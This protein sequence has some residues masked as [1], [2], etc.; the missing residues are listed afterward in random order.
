MLTHR[1]DLT[2]RYRGD[3]VTLPS[4]KAV[5]NDRATKTKKSM[6]AAMSPKHV[7]V[8]KSGAKIFFASMQHSKDKTNYQGKRYDFIGFDELTHFTWEEYS[9][10]F[11]RNR[12]SKR[13]KSTKKTICYIRATTN[14]G[15][16]GHGWVKER[17]IDAAE[18]G[19]TIVEMVEV[20]MPDGTVR[21]IKRDRVFIQ[22]TI[23]DNQALLEND[24]GYLGSLALLPEKERDALLYGVWDVFE[25][26]YFTEFRVRPDPVKCKEAGITPEQALERHQWTHVIPAFD[27]N[28]GNRSGWKIYRSYDFGYAKPFSCAWWAVDYDGVMYRIMEMYGCTK[29]PNEG[30]KW[31]PDQ[32]F[33]QIAEIERTHPWLR[34]KNIMGVADPAIW[35]SSRG[36]SIQE[37]AAKYGVYFTPGDHE[38]I[39]GWMQCHYR[40]QFDHNG[41]SRMYV[42][43]NCKAFIRTIPLMMARHEAAHRDIA[44]GN[45]PRASEIYDRLV[46][47]Y[48]KS[49]EVELPDGSVRDTSEFIDWVIEQYAEA[50]SMTDYTADEVFEEIVCDSMADMNAFGEDMKPIVEHFLKDIKAQA[51]QMGGSQ[52]VETTVPGE[53]KFSREKAKAE[54]KRY[55]YEWFI[56]KPDMVV[57]TI[58]DPVTMS[59]ADI[60]NEAKKNAVTVGKGDPNGTVTVHVRDTDM[61][62]IIG[63][64]GLKHSIDRRLKELGPIILKAGEILQNSIKINELLPKKADAVG[65]YVLIGAARN[66]NG[67]FYVVRSVVNRFQSKLVSMDVLYAIN[68]KKEAAAQNVQTASEDAAALNAP[69][70]TGNPL[71]VTAPTISISELLENVNAHFP[72]VL[73]EDVLKH[74]G[75]DRRPDGVL[76]ES[77]LYSR[78]D[79]T[80]AELQR[81]NALL[82]ERLEYWKGQVKRTDR[83]TVRVADVDKAAK[84]ILSEYQSKAEFGD[85]LG[86]MKSLADKIVDYRPEEY[87]TTDN[88]S[89][90]IDEIMSEDSIGISA[91][92]A[93]WDQVKQDAKDIARDIVQKSQVMTNEFEMET[94]KDIKAYL[95]SVKI[96]LGSAR[97]DIPDFNNF[98]KRNFGR[99][100]LSKEGVPMDS[101]WLDLQDQFG[102]GF[103]P[104]EIVHPAD[105]IQHIEGLYAAMEPDYA[106]PYQGEMGQNVEACANEILDVLF[107]DAVRQT[108]KTFAG[109]P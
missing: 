106:N 88:R 73:P 60:I 25:G 67:D 89:F 32:Q 47:K 2:Y 45:L 84:S 40:L 8:F 90:G 53:V 26:Q 49:G 41:Y 16:V 79:P 75:H 61:D 107:S 23:F 18:P 86:A 46:E 20:T 76:G 43:D 85:V 28:A 12:P 11:S 33:Q 71:Y 99:F 1:S 95:R 34:G 102:K 15:G 65:S 27:I 96:S 22:A 51:E 52:S 63:R 36:E 83:K 13:P 74:F 57:T 92:D 62:V 72:D 7:W 42:F 78:E 21:K 58:G 48:G 50:Y 44:Q 80:V 31:T 39:P 70:F 17:F 81:E 64:D 5:L 68:A 24:P 101:L 105:Q 30:I 109:H 69:I 54:P 29:I 37:T 66:P 103:F 59:R 55:S 100:T 6:C 94:F 108:A 82:K 35:D 87:E 9:Y 19:Q 4:E 10:M 91:E 98:R 56:Q 93:F 104:E 3:P 77:A 14:P 38:R 97:A